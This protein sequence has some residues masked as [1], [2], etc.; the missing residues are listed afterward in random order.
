MLF[1]QVNCQPSV[2]NSLINLMSWLLVAALLQQKYQQNL[3]LV[4]GLSLVAYVY[5]FCNFLMVHDVLTEI[6]E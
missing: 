6:G 5:C 2:L 1:S 4:N 3:S